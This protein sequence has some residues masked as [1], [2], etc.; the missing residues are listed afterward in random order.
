MAQRHETDIVVIGAGPV[1][2]FQVFEA[3]MLDMRCHV[4][5][6]LDAVGG[7][8]TALYPEKPIYDIPGY[9]EI[10]ASELIRQLD[11]QAAPFDPVCHLDQQVVALE[12][13]AGAFVVR[14]SA[15]TEIVCKAI[16]VAAGCGAFGPNRPPLSGI[17]TYEET[18]SVAYL[19]TRKEDH[20]GKKVVIAGGGDSALDWALGL[21][22]IAD[23]I[24]VVHRR[25][26]FRAAPDSVKRMQALV[27]SG[28]VELVVPYHLHGLDGEGGQ[29]SAVI[30]ADLDGNER[31]LDADLLLPFYG[32]RMELGPIAA[33]GLNLEKN[34]I[35]TD[36]AT[37][38]TSTPGIYGVGD[39]VTYPGKLKLILSGFSETAMAAHAIH[40]LVYPDKPLHFQYSTTRGVPGA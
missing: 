28:E 8:C 29:L 5:D 14:T 1:G 38:Q 35:T 15:D 32:L 34:L 37:A 9:P 7:Q 3:G 30:V 4:V 6:T 10:E 13:E 24:M 20:R 11:Q 36:P 2:L 17:E 40:D 16:V 21:H 23:E 25:D 26:R 31:R 33:W 12:G 18:G 19:V 27:E 39:I 22:G